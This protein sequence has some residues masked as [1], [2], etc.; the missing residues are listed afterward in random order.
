MAK[1]EIRFPPGT[2]AR[3]TA[4]GRAA[5]ALAIVAALAGATVWTPRVWALPFFTPKPSTGGHPAPPAELHALEF[6]KGTWTCRGVVEPSGDRPAHLTKGK[7]TY[8]WD[9]GNYFQ[10]VTNQD[11]RTKEDPAPR[12]A[13]GYLGFDVATQQVTVALF[14][15]GGGRMVA[16]SPVW[17][18]DT[19]KFAGDSSRP[20]EPAH[21]EQ[22]ITRK[23]DTE[24]L[25]VLEGIGGDGKRIKIF[26]EKCVKNGK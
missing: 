16:T 17:S 20:G 6:F 24:Y 2:T 25:S 3:T 14:Y 10:V 26:H 8:K 12:W 5:R 9:L 19:L 18:E 21:V 13:R 23:T 15:V 4:R 1:D 11:E 22:S 7:A